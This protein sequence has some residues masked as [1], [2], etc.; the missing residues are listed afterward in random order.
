MMEKVPAAIYPDATVEKLRRRL[1]SRLL[2]VF[3]GWCAHD[4]KAKDE[5]ADSV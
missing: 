2:E 5:G 1:S 3:K 4:V